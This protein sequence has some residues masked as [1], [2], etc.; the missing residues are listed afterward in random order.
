VLVER[1]ARKWK[2]SSSV[3]RAVYAKHQNSVGW[4]KFGVGLHE[5]GVG[6]HEF[7][8]GLHEFGVGR[9]KNLPDDKKDP[10]FL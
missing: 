3:L 9:L 10:Q 4:L 8:V 7:G 6:R 5:F 1:N 2:V